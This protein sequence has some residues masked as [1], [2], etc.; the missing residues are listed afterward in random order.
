MGE[1]VILERSKGDE[2]QR[3]I[4]DRNYVAERP[5]PEWDRLKEDTSGFAYS[6]LGTFVKMILPSAVIGLLML[7]GGIKLIDKFFALLGG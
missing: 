5:L 3:I 6:F 4:F 1:K 7:V 2:V